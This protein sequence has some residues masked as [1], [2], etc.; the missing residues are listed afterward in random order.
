L[1]QI[2]NGQKKIVKK[3][4]G[5]KARG[6]LQHPLFWYDDSCFYWYLSS[7]IDVYYIGER[8]WFVLDSLTVNDVVK[9]AM[10]YLLDFALF[11]PILCHMTTMDGV[12]I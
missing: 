12:Q 9:I 3:T 5:K 11:R 4:K 7:C 6:V 1:S 8:H 10:S 2:G